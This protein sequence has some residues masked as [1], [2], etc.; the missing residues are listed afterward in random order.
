[1]SRKFVIGDRARFAYG[2][3]EYLVTNVFNY[4]NGDQDV[5]LRIKGGIEAVNIK[6]NSR[7]LEL[8]QPIMSYDQKLAY[9]MKTL[10]DVYSALT[11]VGSEKY[12]S[13][14][15]HMIEYRRQMRIFK[16]DKP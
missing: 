16:G 14:M 6:V 10:D 3:E 13:A 1:M 8:M 11:A 15:R 9:C 4:D 2:T 12:T 7:L 5:E